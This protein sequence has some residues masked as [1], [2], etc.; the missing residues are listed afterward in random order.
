MEP[1]CLG[2]M[3]LPD[4]RQHMKGCG[5]PLIFST[6]NLDKVLFEF[7]QLPCEAGMVEQEL[8]CF[9]CQHPQLIF[10]FPGNG[11][12]S[13]LRTPSPEPHL[14]PTLLHTPLS[15][16]LS[17]VPAQ[18]L[19]WVNWEESGQTGGGAMGRHHAAPSKC[20]H[21]ITTLMTVTHAQDCVEAFCQDMPVF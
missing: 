19:S 20:G 7:C 16:A 21:P 2:V 13:W 8:C 6:Q 5:W 17:P 10:E 12:S 15:A 3:G 9:C 1:G 4:A 18:C 11:K 14:T